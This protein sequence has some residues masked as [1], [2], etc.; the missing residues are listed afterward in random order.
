MQTWWTLKKKQTWVW[1]CGIENKSSLEIDLKAA[2]AE[3]RLHN[4]A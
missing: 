2:S 1:E 4:L 3:M